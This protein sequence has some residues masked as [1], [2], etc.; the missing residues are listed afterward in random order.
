VIYAYSYIFSI[1]D[2]FRGILEQARLM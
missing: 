1:G 2:Y